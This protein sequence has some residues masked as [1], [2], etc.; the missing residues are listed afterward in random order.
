MP[1]HPRGYEAQ[2]T[3]QGLQPPAENQTIIE[4]SVPAFFDCKSALTG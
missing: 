2:T 1:H 3:F 4:V